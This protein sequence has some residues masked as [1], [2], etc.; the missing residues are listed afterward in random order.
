MGFIYFQKN[1]EGS[2][3]TV[4]ERYSLETHDWHHRFA[5]PLLQRCVLGEGNGTHSSTLAWTVPWTE[6]PGG[7]Q[8]MGSRRVGHN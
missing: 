1:S 2:N 3:E 5:F 4:F 6:E 7:L 8:A